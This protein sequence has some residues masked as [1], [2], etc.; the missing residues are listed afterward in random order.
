MEKKELESYQKAGKIAVQVKE[1]ARN[2]I[3]PGMPLLEIVE[4][5]EK[6]IEELGGEPAFPVNLSINEIAAHYTPSSIDETLANGLLKIDIGIEINGFI[7][8]TA[9]SLDLTKNKEHKKLIE[10]SEQALKQSIKSIKENP[11][12]TLSEIGKTIQETIA[13]FGFSPIRNLS[14]H[15]LGEFTIHSGIT[16][17]NYENHNN[18]VLESGAYA[19]EPFATTGEGIVRDGGKSNIYRLEKE[20]AIRDPTARKIYNFVIEN[21]S[22]LPFCERWL[23]KEFGS[24]TRIGLLFLEKAGVL[25]SYAQ[26]VEKSNA[27]ISQAENTILINK[28]EIEVTTE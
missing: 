18:K 26:L 13:S 15:S 6:K 24:K 4:K 25:H 21:Y 11:K 3:K 10:A 23:T 27:P 19:I 1:Y 5:I 9:F 28:K 7:A 12:I 2:L 14:G 8:D 16:I 22:T 17:P 20:G